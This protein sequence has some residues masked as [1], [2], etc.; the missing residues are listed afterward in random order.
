MHSDSKAV[1]EY[2][3]ELLYILENTVRVDLVLLP[4]NLIINK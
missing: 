4:E 2:S 3:L 1:V